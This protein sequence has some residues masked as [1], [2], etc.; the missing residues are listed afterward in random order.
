MGS[1]LLDSELMF[2]TTNKPFKN[3]FPLFF[4]LKSCKSIFV[5]ECYTLQGSHVKWNLRWKHQPFEATETQQLRIRQQILKQ[6]VISN[7]KD[8][9]W[10]RRTHLVV[11][12]SHQ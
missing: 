8:Q 10:W 9:L 11:F 6:V 2:W 1:C 5:C 7:S 12:Q 4:A 3:V